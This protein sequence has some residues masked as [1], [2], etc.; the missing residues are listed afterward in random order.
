MDYSVSFFVSFRFFCG[1]GVEDV[2]K[3]KVEDWRKRQ[4]A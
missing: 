4:K 2:D 3:G 1:A